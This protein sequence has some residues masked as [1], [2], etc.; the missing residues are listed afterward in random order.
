M[1]KNDKDAQSTSF[2]IKRVK[3]SKDTVDGLLIASWKP[4]EFM[5]VS[6][7][8]LINHIKNHKVPAHDYQ[9]PYEFIWFLTCDNYKSFNSTAGKRKRSGGR[10]WNARE[11]QHR[12]N[13][14][15]VA[16]TWR[17]STAASTAWS[18]PH[19]RKGANTYAPGI[20][21]GIRLTSCSSP[22]PCSTD[23]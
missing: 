9:K 4:Y 20:L 6:I 1:F 21:R 10:V 22:H 8:M 23:L 2:C 11:L 14:S 12:C 16:A 18:A 15:A 13:A 3:T 17:C 19:V 5:G 7:I